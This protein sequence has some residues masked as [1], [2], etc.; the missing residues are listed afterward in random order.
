V[1]VPALLLATVFAC[2][3]KA[4]HA[5]SKMANVSMRC[6]SACIYLLVFWL[7]ILGG[8]ALLVATVFND[9]CDH[10]LTGNAASNGKGLIEVGALPA[11]RFG[12]V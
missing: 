6:G 10:M 5:P 3:R 7:V 11:R 2:M 9:T 8:I 4:D 12:V 1:F